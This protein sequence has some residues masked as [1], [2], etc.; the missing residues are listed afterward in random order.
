MG[1]QTQ[2]RR[3]QNEPWQ[4]LLGKRIISQLIHGYI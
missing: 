4:F 2:R 3:S 1:K